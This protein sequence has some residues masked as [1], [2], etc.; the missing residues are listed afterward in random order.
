MN[1]CIELSG[2]KPV[3]ETSSWTNVPATLRRM[4]EASHFGK[5][6]VTVD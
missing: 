4:E 6:V 5:L 2:L 3:I 1:R